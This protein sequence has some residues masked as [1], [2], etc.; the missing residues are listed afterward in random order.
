M[1]D[2]VREHVKAHAA[3]LGYGTTD[4]V[5]I[6]IIT[7]AKTIHSEVVD[8]RRWWDELFCVV[9]VNGMLI[10]Y[11]GAKTTGDMSARECGW[12]FAQ[13][14]ICEVKATS[15]TITVYERVA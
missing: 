12:E 7:E 4:D 13:S 6:E 10:G 15:K 14:S 1:N 11:D 5:L 8:S 2:K 9:E 3:A